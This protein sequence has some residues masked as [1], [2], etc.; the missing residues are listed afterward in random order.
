MR[1]NCTRTLNYFEVK[2]WFIAQRSVRLLFIGFFLL[3]VTKSMGSPDVAEEPTLIGTISVAFVNSNLIELSLPTVG[4]GT[5]RIIV[6]RQGS[7]PEA[8]VDGVSYGSNSV[9]GT[10]SNISGSGSYVVYNGIGS[11]PSVVTIS[12]LAAMTQYFLGVYEFN[13]DTDGPNYL[14]STFSSVNA[15]TTDASAS[16]DYFRTRVSGNWNDVKTWESSHNNITWFNASLI[17]SNASRGISIISSHTVEVNSTVLADQLVIQ[18]SAEL[19]ITG[20]ILTLY[21]GSGTDMV[22][23]GT[24]SLEFS[25]SFLKRSGATIQFTGTG[26]YAHK[27]NNGKSRNNIPIATWDDGSVCE[28]NGMSTAVGLVGLNQ[29]FSNFVWN[30]TSAG[31]ASFTFDGLLN[32]VRGNLT[33]KGN[34]SVILSSGSSSVTMNFGSLD[35]ESP[36][37]LTISNGSSAVSLNIQDDIQIQNGSSVT[38]STNIGGITINIGGDWNN[39]GIFNESNSTVVFNGINQ[40]CNETGFANLGLTNGAKTFNGSVLSIMGNF[41][42]TA[43]S[44]TL[45]TDV[46]FT[47]NAAQTISAQDVPF[48]NVFFNGNGNKTFAANASISGEV[49]FGTGTATVDFDGIGNDRTVTFTSSASGHARLANIQSY[50]ITGDITLER[51][52]GLGLLNQRAYRFMGHPFNVAIG[53]FDLTD[54]IDITGKGGAA[55]GFTPTLANSPSAYRY[56]NATGAWLAYT[57]TNGSGSNA[58]NPTEAARIFVRG[59]KGQGL[60][61]QPYTANPVTIDMRGPVNTGNV[62]ISLTPGFDGNN[63]IGNPYPSAIQ[64]QGIFD[65][66]ANLDGSGFWVWNPYMGESGAYEMVP[67][68]D[69]YQFP[70]FA[71]MFVGVTGNTNLLVTEADKVADNPSIT[72]LKTANKANRLKL[73][74]NR[75]NKTHDLL[76]VFHNT[77]SSDSKDAKDSRKMINPSTDFYALSKEGTKLSIDARPLANSTEI[78]LGIRTEETGNYTILADELAIPENLVAYLHDSYTGTVTELSMGSSYEFTTT[79]E[80]S[81]QGENR[82]KLTFAAARIPIAAVTEQPVQKAQLSIYPNPVRGSNLNLSID[83]LT[84]GEYSVRITSIEGKTISTSVL[85]HQGGRSLERV[86]LPAYLPA[87]L[88]NIELTNAEGFRSSM[89]LVKE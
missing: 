47:G 80:A 31:G 86:Q 10:G 19:R 14:T 3:I 78:A 5:S 77:E 36:A 85:N 84:K 34:R 7:L 12:G 2:N 32:N 39:L 58:W 15:T 26:K 57:N 60:D 68:G 25:S 66:V 52:L 48:T 46:Q 87:G 61:G 69:S 4:N 28:I 50:N 56:N 35:V 6:I 42:S 1:N 88:Y 81:S 53:L 59:T 75:E 65:G 33:V 44:V 74:L 29:S 11:G 8:P 23:S 82:F 51:Y 38:A 89:K 24:Y 43:S 20:G 21:N 49:T 9:Y 41:T 70:A 79:K 83:G 76:Y 16:T 67:Y 64:T 40:T 71:G 63:F 17:P 18:E 55:N 13:E 45:P 54:D 22:V 27:V 62:N 37:N 72:L 30:I 73:V